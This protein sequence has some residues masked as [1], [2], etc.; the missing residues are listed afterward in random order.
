[1]TVPRVLKAAMLA[2]NPTA[3][4]HNQEVLSEIRDVVSRMAGCF[5][6]AAFVALGGASAYQSFSVAGTFY[7]LSGTIVE[8]GETDG[9]LT[10]A[11]SGVGVTY[12]SENS[13]RLQI[14]A[15]I[16]LTDASGGAAFRL[17]AFLNG[18]AMEYATASARTTFAMPYASLAMSSVVDA[19]NGDV[20]DLRMANT[21]GTG[22]LS[23]YDARFVFTV[24]TR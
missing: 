12:A 23:L 1:M 4:R 5:P 15:S 19:V 6:G 20:V 22:G 2:D 24:L 10:V 18:V 16:R 9:R 14:S 7:P 21:T 3:E 11:S 17:Q 13:C 8:V